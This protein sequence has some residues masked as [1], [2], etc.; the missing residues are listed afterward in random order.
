MNWF[1]RALARLLD[2]LTVRSVGTLTLG[3]IRSFWD[4]W[5]DPALQ[6]MWRPPD[7]L[8]VMNTVDPAEWVREGLWAY[9]REKGVL[10]GEII[11][12]GFDSYA[13]VFHPA[14]LQR[15]DQSWEKVRWSDVAGWNGKVVHPQM[16]FHRIANLAEPPRYPKPE[17]G[18]SPFMGR[19]FR[20]RMP[21]SGQCAQGVYIHARTLLFLH[22][23]RV[24]VPGGVG[25]AMGSQAESPR[26]WQ[27]ILSPEWPLGRRIILLF[28]VGPVAE[29][30]VA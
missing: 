13:R 12:E 25:L 11:P 21:V 14:E 18:R 28:G 26:L 5:R 24:W 15:P 3:G 10:A 29:H 20:G 4:R 7:G 19:P 9:D 1:T 27:G 16:Q 30:L 17:W 22:L 8:E 23:G 2:P 6:D